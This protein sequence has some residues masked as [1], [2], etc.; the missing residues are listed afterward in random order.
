[1]KQNHRFIETLNDEV[2]DH[3]KKE[4]NEKDN[5]H[6]TRIKWFEILNMMTRE[7]R[8]VYSLELVKID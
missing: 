6:I 7:Y 2:M 4:M 3:M 5:E 8:N 1:M